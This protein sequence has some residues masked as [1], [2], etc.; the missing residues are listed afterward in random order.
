MEID[1]GLEN[2][3]IK[4]GMNHF[5]INDLTKSIKTKDIL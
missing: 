4:S 2:R 1:E 5:Y 3:I